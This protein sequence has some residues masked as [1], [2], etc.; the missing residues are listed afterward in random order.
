MPNYVSMYRKDILFIYSF[1]LFIYILIIYGLSNFD[2]VLG[3]G[4]QTRVSGANS[5][6]VP[7][8]NSLAHYRLNYQVTL[9]EKQFIVD[10]FLGS[11][12]NVWPFIL[13]TLVKF[14]IDS[15]MGVLALRLCLRLWKIQTKLVRICRRF[16]YHLD[17]IT[18]VIPLCALCHGSIFPG[19]IIF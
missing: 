6:H 9:Q 1:Y 18:D 10:K 13:D 2:H 17:S 14:K 5:T 8:V 15:E 12:C 4:S 11:Y 7:Q 19:E 3:V 16:K